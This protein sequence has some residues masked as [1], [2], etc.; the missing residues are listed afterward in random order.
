[1]RQSPSVSRAKHLYLDYVGNARRRGIPW[2]LTRP[3]F[4]EIAQGDCF[5]CGRPPVVLSPRRSSQAGTT[6][7]AN[8]VDR[9]DS[10]K[11][12][13]PCN[14]V[15]CCRHCNWAKHDHTPEAFIQHAIRVAAR[16]AALYKDHQHV[17]E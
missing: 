11:G 14:C 5:Y 12:Y 10:S 1:M 7:A 4:L 2:G 17:F 6:F 15:P 8:G 16:F 3:Q 9:L 13:S